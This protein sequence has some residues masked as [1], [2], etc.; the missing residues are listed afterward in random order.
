MSRAREL[1]PGPLPWILV[2][3]GLIGCARRTGAPA[4]VPLPATADTGVVV[5][6]GPTLIGFFPRPTTATAGDTAQL[7]RLAQFQGEL[8]QVRDAFQQAGVRV[9]EQY[10][11]TL[12]VQESGLGL[13]IY[14]PP[15]GT[16]GIGYYLAEPG[17]AA[18]IIHGLRTNAEIREAALRYF[19]GHASERRV[20][21]R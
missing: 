18:D 14:V 8:A 17:R 4:A 1:R 10:V 16:R 7:R 20:S 13:Q 2:L 6:A 11:D 19:H 9:Y 21:V 5:I 3:A 12:V 15:A